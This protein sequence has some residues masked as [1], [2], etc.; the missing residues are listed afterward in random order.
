MAQRN[1]QENVE[2]FRRARGGDTGAKKRLLQYN[3]ND[4]LPDGVLR[5]C[6]HAAS[7]FAHDIDCGDEQLCKET[8]QKLLAMKE[9][10]PLFQID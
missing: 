6:C 1:A 3:Y 10:L 2:N 7:T 5:G 9:E 8:A 4:Q